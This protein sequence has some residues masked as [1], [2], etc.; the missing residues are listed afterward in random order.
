[1]QEKIATIMFCDIMNSSEYAN[2]LSTTN[3]YKY[4]IKELK[5][6]CYEERDYFVSRHPEYIPLPK[7]VQTDD[8]TEYNCQ[9]SA[10]GDEIKVVFYSGDEWKDAFNIMECAVRLKLRWL[11]GEFNRN[12]ILQNKPPEDLAIGMNTGPLIIEENE[13]EGFS[14]N[15]AKRVESECRNGTFCRILIHA[16]TVTYIDAYLQRPDTEG[17]VDASF[18]DVVTFSGKGIAQEIPRREIK[19]FLFSGQAEVLKLLD[20]DAKYF[21][22]HLFAAGAMAPYPHFIYS[23]LLST[24]HKLGIDNYTFKYIEDLGTKMYKYFESPDIL[25]LLIEIYEYRYREMYR[26]LTPTQKAEFMAAWYSWCRKDEFKY[27]FMLDEILKE[28]SK[29]TTYFKHM[30]TRK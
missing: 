21:I 11:F 9:F 23:V 17:M 25:E 22:R 5:R 18:D 4:I 19:Y 27:R 29:M 26:D 13:P 14:M 3:Y 1:M 6:I 30:P 28:Q 24:L 12:R 8:N 15:V 20:V 10:V 2:V 7:R 16:N